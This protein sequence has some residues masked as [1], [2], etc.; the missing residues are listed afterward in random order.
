MVNL[1]IDRHKVK[2][3]HIF[4]GWIDI[5]KNK[6]LLNKLNDEVSMAMHVANT[7]EAL[8]KLC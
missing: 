3:K 6:P 1:L 2:S 7:K 4:S 8:H 5:Q